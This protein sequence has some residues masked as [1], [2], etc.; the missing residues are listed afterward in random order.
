MCPIKCSHFV[1]IKQDL[2]DTTGDFI[3]DRIVM[4]DK[5]SMPLIHFYTLF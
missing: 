4:C 3:A 5:T 2:Q 1:K